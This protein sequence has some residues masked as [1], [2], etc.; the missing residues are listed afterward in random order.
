MQTRLARR[1]A[2]PLTLRLT[3]LGVGLAFVGTACGSD[4]PVDSGRIVVATTSIWADVVSNVACDGLAE[5]RTLVPPGSDPHAFE[6]SLADRGVLESAALIVA[7]GLGLEEGLEDTI[8]TVEDGGTAVIRVA[9][10]TTTID[11]TEDL[12]HEGGDPHLWFDPTRVAEA[13]SS[14]AEALIAEVGLDAGAVDGCL[15]SY[16]S[17]LA[18]LD[19]EIAALV[20]PL[21]TD[22]RNLVT[23]HDVLAYFADRYDFVV[24]GTIIPQASTLAATNPAHL[25]ALA[26]LIEQHRVPAIFVDAGESTADA[27]ALA[28]RV[29]GVNVVPLLTGTLGE[30]GSGT[31]TYVGF[32]RTNARIIV[33]SLG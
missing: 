21:P 26:D 11:A 27:E 10:H 23:G 29:D 19:G 22:R 31:G 9:E 25:E 32:M 4:Q 1:L 15:A 8:D 5:V 33:D 13:L 6:P 2:T 12:D 14:L 18:T 28:A 20:S 16:R 3:V 30:P 7:N 24:T 17:E